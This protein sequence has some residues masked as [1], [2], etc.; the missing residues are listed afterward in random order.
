VWVC[1][2]PGPWKVTVSVSAG[3]AASLDILSVTVRP[4]VRT[5]T[6]L[7]AWGMVLVAGAVAI[8]TVSSD[9]RRTNLM[10]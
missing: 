6:G 8:P 1:A 10:G 3:S 7:P 2:P 9:T 5:S 4:A